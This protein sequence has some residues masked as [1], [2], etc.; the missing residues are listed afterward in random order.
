MREGKV[1]PERLEANIGA[2]YAEVKAL[3][4]SCQ[5]ASFDTQ[6]SLY[7]AEFISYLQKNKMSEVRYRNFINAAMWP[8]MEA[9]IAASPDPDSFTVVSS[10]PEIASL[11]RVFMQIYSV[12]SGADASVFRE[13]LL[14]TFV[15]YYI[16]YQ[17]QK[18]RSQ[19][20][21]VSPDL[22]HALLHTELRKYPV[23][24]LQ[25][26]FPCIYVELPE[27]FRVY[28]RITGWHAAEGAYVVSDDATQH[29][30]WRIMMTGKPQEGAFEDDDSLFHFTMEMPE[31]STVEDAIKHTFSKFIDSPM[32][33]EEVEINGN[34]CKV[35]RG[36]ESEEQRD[37]FKNMEDKMVPVFRYIMNVVIY[38]MSTDAD[39]TFWNASKE[40]R[41]LRDRAMKAQGSKRKKLFSRLNSVDA[42]PRTLLG[43]NLVV[44]RKK[45]SVEYGQATG[46]GKWAVRTYVAGYWNTYWVGKGRTE[47]RTMLV[48]PHWRGPEEAPLTRTERRVAK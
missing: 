6:V 23:D 27:Q 43:R 33:E 26:P 13:M 47:R 39:I 30:S 7:Y 22:E 41:R 44:D 36:F 8:P 28:N 4:D 48:K 1:H 16:R 5:V 34:I 9:V 3:W 18:H 2:E 21:T 19:I 40:Y 11:Y 32:V 31:G 10:T 14:T 17:H 38:T 20:Y 25:L 46:R 12:G 42:E 15:A 24:M 45:D 35:R 29:R 37:H